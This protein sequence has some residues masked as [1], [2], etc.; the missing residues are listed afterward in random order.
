MM[1]KRRA[2]LESWLAKFWEA[3][4][5]T[6]KFGSTDDI[7]SKGSTLLNKA[8]L[9]KHLGDIEQFKAW[10]VK[11]QSRAIQRRYIVMVSRC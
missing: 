9:A 2:T 10:Y 3:E 6:G 8:M 4:I 1:S 11:R 7:G 5:A